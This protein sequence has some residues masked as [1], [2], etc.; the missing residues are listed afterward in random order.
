LLGSVVDIL[1]PDNKLQSVHGYL[2]ISFTK[3]P[4]ENYWTFE[5]RLKKSEIIHRESF[6]KIDFLIVFKCV[7]R[8][9]N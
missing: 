4:Q 9:K 2:V 3:N 6:P 8:V 7:S 1:E 5:E